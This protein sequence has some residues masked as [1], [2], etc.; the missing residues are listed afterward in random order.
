MAFVTLAIKSPRQIIFMPLH[1]LTVERVVSE[2]PDAKTFVLVPPFPFE[3]GQYLMLESPAMDDP[4]GGS[5]PFSIA[6]SPTEPF[7]MISTLMRDTPFKHWLGHVTEDDT[8]R[9]TG[10]FG[11]F[12]LDDHATKLCFLVGGIG[13]TPVRSMLKFIIDKK[14]TTDIIV[15]WSNR[16]GQ[17]IMYRDDMALFE[18]LGMRIVHTITRD[19]SWHGRHGRIDAAM[20]RDEVRDF[21]D[22]LFYVVGPPA[23]VAAMRAALGECGVAEENIRTERFEGY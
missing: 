12:V 7:I 9:A 22:R 3:P 17:D 23:M 15:L 16:T 18:S 2:T 4:Q 20:I 13:I 19:P 10:P 11:S 6:S 21:R 14:R 8:V 5:R 1:E